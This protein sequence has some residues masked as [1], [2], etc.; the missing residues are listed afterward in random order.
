MVLV[1]DGVGIKYHCA[2]VEAW[3]AAE[4]NTELQSLLPPGLQSEHRPSAEHPY[5]C[6]SSG[7][8]CSRRK[9]SAGSDWTQRLCPVTVELW[10]AA[11]AG[12][13]CLPLSV[14]A[15]EIKEKE[16]ALQVLC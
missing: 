3:T 14:H 5:G 2:R 7:Q 8:C 12:T 13:V 4:L 11:R 15:D 9:L 10:S 6:R 1:L 16:A